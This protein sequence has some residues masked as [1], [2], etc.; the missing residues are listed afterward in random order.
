MV[1]V[2]PAFPKT[3][4]VSQTPCFREGTYSVG[5][6]WSLKLFLFPGY[7][8]AWEKNDDAI[9]QYVMVKWVGSSNYIIYK[10]LS[11]EWLCW[12][13][14]P[15]ITNSAPWK[16]IL[17]NQA[18]LMPGPVDTPTKNPSHRIPPRF[19]GTWAER[20]SPHPS[21]AGIGHEFEKLLTGW[22]F[23]NWRVFLRPVF[24]WGWHTNLM[25]TWKWCNFEGFL[26]F[27]SSSGLVFM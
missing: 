23:L 22:E 9:W 7:Q 6:K 11:Y 20:I 17:S 18:K 14:Q 27:S 19:S 4:V 3:K 16:P 25:Q 26:R 24:F 12:C 21:H 10:L 2:I 5:K 15:S 1:H 8:M 13:A